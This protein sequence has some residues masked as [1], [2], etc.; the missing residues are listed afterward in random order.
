MLKNWVTETDT[1]KNE[2]IEASLEFQLYVK[3]LSNWNITIAISPEISLSFNYMLNNWVTET[4]RYSSDQTYILGF[5]YML[6]NWVTETQ[7]L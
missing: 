6:K 2:I 3:E 4:F 7:Y 5:N 1:N